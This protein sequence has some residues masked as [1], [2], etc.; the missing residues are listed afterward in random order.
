MF[1]TALGIMAALQQ[2][3]A[4]AE[5]ARIRAAQYVW[6]AEQCRVAAMP[7][8]ATNLRKLMDLPSIGEN[9]NE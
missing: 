9:G 7:R 3:K 5:L 4:D 8:K 1:G 6:F 2:E